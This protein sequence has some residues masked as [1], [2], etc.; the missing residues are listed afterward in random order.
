MP[1]LVSVKPLEGY[2]L[3]LAY[4]DGVEGTV[5]LSKWVGKGVFALWEDER[6]FRDVRIG[7]AGEL[8]WDNQVDLCSDALY[9]MI[10]GKRPEDIFPNLKVVQET[11][12]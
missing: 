4:D 12:A 5:D 1:R 6:R 11:H 3:W 7:D 8:V 9:L 10:T 2:R